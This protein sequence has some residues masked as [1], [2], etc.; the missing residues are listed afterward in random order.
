MQLSFPIV[1]NILNVNTLR[2][3]IYS[4]DVNNSTT[5]PSISMKA[6]Y[7]FAITFFNHVKKSHSHVRR[8]DQ[9]NSHV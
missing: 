3:K 7:C 6:V 2:I 4:Y 1:E 5:A 9:I 8:D